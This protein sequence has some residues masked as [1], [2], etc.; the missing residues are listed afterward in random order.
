M[1]YDQL[2]NKKKKLN[3]I[4]NNQ[5][6]FKDNKKYYEGLKEGVNESFDLFNLTIEFYKKYKDNVKLLMNEQNK[7][8]LKWISYYN[9]QNDINNSNY[10]IRYNKWLFD[11]LFLNINNDK[12]IGLLEIY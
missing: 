11:N 6:N 12:K 10:K 9:N 5:D 8:W 2:I 3:K 4:I 1:K 7:L